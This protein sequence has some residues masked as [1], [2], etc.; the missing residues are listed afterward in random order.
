MFQYNVQH[1]CR[2]ARCVAS[3][4]RAVVQERVQTELTESLIEHKPVG[5][6]L[7]NTHA[8]HN[9]HLI[10]SVLPHDLTR[11]IPYV[12]NRKAQHAE[13]AAKL[14]DSQNEK[15]LKTAEK[16]KKVVANLNRAAELE[17]QKSLTA[18]GSTS[19][20]KRRRQDTD[21]DKVGEQP[22]AT[23]STE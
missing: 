12:T 2:N 16:K 3:G 5:I 21:I 14:R 22:P 11:P 9:A 1:D 23:T 17:A 20:T 8:F 4:K 6:F 18:S 15:R 10:R 7:V 13:T 19:S